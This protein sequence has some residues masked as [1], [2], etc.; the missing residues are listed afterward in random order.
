MAGAVRA[1]DC[2][3]DT[4]FVLLCA[5]AQWF[6]RNSAEGLTPRQVPIEG[7][8]AKWL[9]THRALVQQ[10]AGLDSLALLGAHPQR[11]HF[12]YLDPDHLAAGG[13]RHDSATV[14]D[15]MAPEYLP[16]VVL[17][18]ENKDSAMHFPDLPGAIS[19]EGAGWGG[20]QAAASFDWIRGAR[21]LVYWGDMDAA[22]LEIVHQFRS[23]GLAVQTILMDTPSFERCERFGAATDAHGAALPVP[24][25]RSVPTLTRFELELRPPLPGDR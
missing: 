24:T 10:L 12:S 16:G 20:A 7:L 9:K 2:Y 11:I 15:T 1:A 8:H 25:L 23:R 21:H 18:S 22:G 5:S 19:L 3:S 6:S 13:R 4:D 14:G 17:I